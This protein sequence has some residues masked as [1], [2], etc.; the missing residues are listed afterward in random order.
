MITYELVEEQWQRDFLD[1]LKDGSTIAHACRKLSLNYSH[2][3]CFAIKSGWSKKMRNNSK[4][5]LRNKSVGTHKLTLS[6]TDILSLHDSGMGHQEIASIAGCTRQ[7]IQKIVS[8]SGRP[9]IRV[10]NRIKNVKKLK[11]KAN[12]R[13][14][15]KIKLE[16]AKTTKKLK[17]ELNTIKKWKPTQIWWSEGVPLQEIAD[18]MG[19]SIQSLNWYIG[20]FRKKYGWFL[21]LRKIYRRQ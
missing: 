12:V 15:E 13:K 18:K 16:V 8:D 4:Y 10:V 9:G 14:L 20:K 5:S 1:L 2:A 19:M 3:W 17:T 11:E 21:P 7:W 6:K